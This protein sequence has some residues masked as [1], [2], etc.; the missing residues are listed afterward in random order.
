[1][2]TEL[3]GS[4]WNRLAPRKS[5]SHVATLSGCLIQFSHRPG[6]PWWLLRAAGLGRGRE[7][8]WSPLGLGNSFSKG[9][10]VKFRPG[11][12]RASQWKEIEKN[13]SVQ[14]INPSIHSFTCLFRA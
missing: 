10:T 3:V 1:M 5:S 12:R 6:D 2:V 9:E 11:Y 4:R 8:A 7:Q 14:E 13:T